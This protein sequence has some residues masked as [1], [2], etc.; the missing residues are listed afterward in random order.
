[1][2]ARITNHV[3]Q[4]AGL[5]LQQL[6]GKPKIEAF[7]KAFVAQVQELETAFWSLLLDRTLA[8]AVGAQ[9]DVLGR[10]VNR[11]R[12][13]LGD[14][15]YRAVLAAWIA[16]NRA[17]GTADDVLRVTVLAVGAANT[18]S[19]QEFFPASMVVTLGNALALSPAIVAAIIRRARMGGVN[20]QVV[21][22]ESD[23][24]ETFAFA[25]GDTEV[26]STDQG[27]ADDSQTTGGEMADVEG[28]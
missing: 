21:Y 1:M 20:T 22:S 13:G 24:D 7:L 9:L 10:V 12:E 28:A 11:E 6:R 15:D 23:D 19:L 17:G 26:A 27:W 4:A 18:V 3:T 8:A 5:L 16:A 14:D 2:I 25:A